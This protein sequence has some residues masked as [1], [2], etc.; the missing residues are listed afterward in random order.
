MELLANLPTKKG[1]MMQ[2][3]LI[4]DF[5]LLK[6]RCGESQAKASILFQYQLFF[7]PYRLN[8]VSIFFHKHLRLYLSL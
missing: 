6:K 3:G 4:L 8:N 7:D 1:A 2:S 5:L